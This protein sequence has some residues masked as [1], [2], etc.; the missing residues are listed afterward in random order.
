MVSLSRILE[1]LSTSCSSLTLP[2]Y[3]SMGCGQGVVDGG[4]SR[5]QLSPLPC[6]LNAD[7]QLPGHDD[8][9]RRP[10]AQ[11]R[12]GRDQLWQI[13]QDG[14]CD[15]P[16]PNVYAPFLSCLL[17]QLWDICDLTDDQ[18]PFLA[19]GTIHLQSQAGAR[20]PAATSLTSR[21]TRSWRRAVLSRAGMTRR[22]TR[23]TWSMTRSSG[24][25]T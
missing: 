23:T 17:I 11:D 5:G 2:D 21:L 10:I 4:M 6:Q 1:S 19:G 7:V 12:R 18:A 3:R 14:R 15:L 22:Q 24:W 9:G 16:R 8:Q 25:R 13:V 20:R